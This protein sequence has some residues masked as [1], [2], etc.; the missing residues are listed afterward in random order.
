MDLFVAIRDGVI[1]TWSGW[2]PHALG[3][4]SVPPLY[5]EIY[6]AVGVH[7]NAATTAYYEW[8]HLK[9]L[10]TRVFEALDGVASD[11]VGRTCSAVAWSGTDTREL[12]EVVTLLQEGAKRRPG[13]AVPP[14]PTL[15]PTA[16][17]AIVWTVKRKGV[18]LGALG[19]L[20]ASYPDGTPCETIESLVSLD[21][22][23]R[24][25]EHELLALIDA[26]IHSAGGETLSPPP[27]VSNALTAIRKFW[28]KLEDTDSPL[29][30]LDFGSVLHTVVAGGAGVS[31]SDVAQRAAELDASMYGRFPTVQV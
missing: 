21:F 6:R 19:T 25:D 17:P 27:P 11:R 7:E 28:T 14:S 16:K 24:M 2:R 29:S 20:H 9:D 12:D 4:E 23:P 10:V 15:R 30:A 13:L 31:W 22:L 3:K 5:R 18:S 1:A 26:A 8:R